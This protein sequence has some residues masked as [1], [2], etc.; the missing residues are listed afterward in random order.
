MADYV[1]LG[2]VKRAD[3]HVPGQELWQ[4]D[5]DEYVIENHV[6]GLVSPFKRREAYAADQ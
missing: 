6:L 3:N 2:H 4:V 5:F 1:Y